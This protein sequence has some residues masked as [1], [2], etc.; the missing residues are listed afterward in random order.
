MTQ[1][2]FFR[3]QQDGDLERIYT[4]IDQLETTAIELRSYAS[5]TEWFVWPALAG[6]LLLGAEQVLTNTRY[7][8]LP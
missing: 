6:L 3:A 1:G 5:F 4:E 2:Q 7:R 8:R